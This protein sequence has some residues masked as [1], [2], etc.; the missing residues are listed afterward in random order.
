MYPVKLDGKVSS[1]AEQTLHAAFAKQLSD[2][3]SVFHSVRWQS[4]DKRYGAQDAEADFV[5]LQPRYGLLV[6][7][8]KGGVIKIDGAA[9][10]W[11]SNGNPIKN[12]I[13]QAQENKYK[14]R[15]RLKRLPFW[16]NHVPRIAHAVAFPD[17]T[18]RGDL[19]I[20]IVPELLLDRAN[21]DKLAQWTAAAFVCAMGELPAESLSD[22]T[23]KRLVDFL[24]P[25]RVLRRGIGGEIALEE[26]ELDALTEQQYRLLSFLGDR[27]RVAIEGCAGSG[28]T[29]LA[30]EQARRLS[31]Q[32]CRV[33]FVC[34]N[35]SLPARLRMHPSLVTGVDVYHFHGLCEEMATKAGLSIPH[36]S[37]PDSDYFNRVLPGLL[38]DA[39]ESLG[40]QYDAIIVDEGQDMLDDWW[41]SLEF[42]LREESGYFFI[43]LDKNQ[44]LYD[45]DMH[46]PGNMEHYSLNENCRNT[47]KIHSIAVAHLPEDTKPV[48]RAPEGREAEEHLYVDARDLHKRL[49]VVLHQLV[50][51][52][53]VRPEEIVILTQ[54][55]IERT[56][57]GERP[58]IGNW[59]LTKQW[60]PGAN[61]VFVTT[62]Y[63]FKG[64]ESPIVILAEISESKNQN[65]ET[66]LYVG[67]SRARNHLI[68][69]APEQMRGKLG[70]H[71]S[72]APT[73]HE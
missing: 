61:E 63:Q 59:K 3:Y 47:R 21:L 43:F 13:V 54:R 49:A 67:C 2:D 40:A 64:L 25:T 62:I 53:K 22:E 70:V 16:R 56:A 19:G 33:L 5:I 4:T 8:V 26:R 9:Q 52:E 11:F 20:E 39:T 45:R 28:K 51:E 57:L 17:V 15:D 41:T 72:F 58:N 32:G 35:Q 38:M 31:T 27:R 69:L 60:P 48:S 42:L 34:Y 65:L 1:F 73:E 55:K 66:L 14:L 36:V 68:V 29:M 71:L 23:V 10:Q 18:I 6:V 46:L 50:S 7:E 24:R 12:P 44:N 30:I 37:D